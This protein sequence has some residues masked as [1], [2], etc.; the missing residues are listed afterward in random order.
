MVWQTAYRILGNY[1]DASDCYQEAFLAALKESKRKRI[2]SWPSLLSRLV[3]RRSIDRIRQRKVQTKHKATIPVE[4]IAETSNCQS[5]AEQA[6]RKAELVEEIR[7]GLASLP[8]KQSV[9]F[10]LRYVEELSYEEIA[11][12][13]ASSPG[14]VRVL[15]H[16]ARTSLRS[17]MASQYQVDSA[18]I[19]EHNV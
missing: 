10:W 6:S 4:L 7:R 9:A 19:G 5:E 16:R 18:N 8:A 15:V 3:T 1:V 17:L 13:T 14:S 2:T 11:E 12:Q